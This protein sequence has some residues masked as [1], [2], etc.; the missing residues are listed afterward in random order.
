[1][2]HKDLFYQGSV[3]TNLLPVEVVTKTGSLSTLSLSQTI[4]RTEWDS[5]LNQTGTK[6]PRKD[7]HTIGVSCLDYNW[8][9]RKKEWE[10]EA[11][12]AQELKWTRVSLSLVTIWFGVIPDLGE[13]WS[14]WLCLELNARALVSSWKVEN[15]DDLNVGVVGVFIA[16]TTKLDCWWRL[17]STGAPDTVRWCTGHCPLAHRTVRCARPGNTSVV[18]CSLCLNP[19]L[20]LFIGLLWTFGTCRTYRL[21]QT[22]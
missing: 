4:P 22:S 1:V 12:Q 7:H 14:L 18:P 10:K 17:P 6:L 21:E 8:D 5:L 2:R 20:S 13:D 15:L 19:F 3:L 9:D 16:P 11:I